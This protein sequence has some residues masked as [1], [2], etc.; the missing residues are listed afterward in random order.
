MR[1][2]HKSEI[3]ISKSETNSKFEFLN[4]QNK[5]DILSYAVAFVSVIRV[6][7]FRNCFEFR[8][9]NFEF[10][11]SRGVKKKIPQGKLWPI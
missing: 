5:N 2:N 4:D 7:G 10:A 6:L 1:N 8:A 3:R 9:S 11:F